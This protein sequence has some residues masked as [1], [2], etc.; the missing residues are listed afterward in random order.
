MEG[1][2]R[3]P[4]ARVIILVV[5]LLCPETLEPCRRA[6][7]T[8]VHCERTHEAL[9]V[10]CWQCGSITSRHTSMTVCVECTLEPSIEEN[11]A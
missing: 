1:A 11:G 6:N 4:G 5:M 8:R 2:S 3:E 10:L 7:C 9:L